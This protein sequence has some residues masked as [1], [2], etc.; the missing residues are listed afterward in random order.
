MLMILSILLNYALGRFMEA[1]P[2]WRKG[3]LVVGVA[4]NLAVLGF[5]KYY[6]FAVRC[7]AQ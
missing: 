1:I 6:G 2:E 7:V 5:F 4:M 3:I